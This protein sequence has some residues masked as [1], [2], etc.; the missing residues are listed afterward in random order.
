MDWK[1]EHNEIIDDYGNMIWQRELE[2]IERKRINERSILEDEENILKDRIARIDIENKINDKKNNSNEEKITEIKKDLDKI[3]YPLKS[4]F[5][6]Y[7]FEQKAKKNRQEER[8]M[9]WY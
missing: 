6:A 5:L 4:P 9:K 2:K 8:Q 1:D 3:Y 7:F